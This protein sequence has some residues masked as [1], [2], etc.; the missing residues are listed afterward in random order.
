MRGKPWLALVPVALLAAS[1]AA[2]APHRSPPAPN[3]L[4]PLSPADEEHAEAGC[5]CTFIV[6]NG[7][8]GDD[9]LQLSGHILL[10]RTR[11]GLNICPISEAQFQGLAG[12]RGS[13]HCPGSRIT[14]RGGPARQVGDDQ[15]QSVATV[16]VTRGGRT[17]LLHGTWACAC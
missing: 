10:S 7:R 11:A 6:R 8:R 9:L 3:P 1:A 17:Q 13:A 15:A 16:V 12:G 5:T 2:P 4:L 14:I